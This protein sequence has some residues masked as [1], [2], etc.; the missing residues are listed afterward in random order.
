M[1]LTKM[2]IL[3]EKINGRPATLNEQICLLANF[4][5]KIKKMQWKFGEISNFYYYSL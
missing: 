4:E 2:K 3:I 1:L 5:R